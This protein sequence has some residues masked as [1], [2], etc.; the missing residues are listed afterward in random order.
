MLLSLKIKNIALIDKMQIDFGNGFHVLTGETG[1][2]KSII[3]DAL[4]LIVGGRAD[5]SLIRSSCDFALVEATVSINNLPE[6]K[7]I[8]DREMISYE[9][10]IIN[11]YRKISTSGRN[12]CRICGEPVPLHI[13]K[14]L[15]DNVIDILGQHSSIVLLE[16]GRQLKV[17][18]NFGDSDHFDKLHNVNQK[19][20][21]WYEAS[22]KLKK[23]I[24]ISKEKELLYDKVY[25][26]L[27]ELD[28]AKIRDGE[29]DEL[30][31][32]RLSLQDSLKIRNAL[33]TSYYNLYG[34]ADSDS[35]LQK[36]KDCVDEFQNIKDLN[37][38][39]ER[40]YNSLNSSYYEIENN[41]FEIRDYRDNLNFDETEEVE[42][43]ERI[44]LIKRLKRKYGSSY[45]E[46]HKKHKD[47]QAKMDKYTSLDE[48]ISVAEKNYKESLNSYREASQELSLSRKAIAIKF[49]KKI[50]DQLHSLGMA[51]AIFKIEVLE[52]KK[53]KPQSNGNDTVIF[54][55]SSN[56]GEPLKP[57]ADA[58][59]GGE[60][61]R[62]MLAIKTIEADKNKIPCLIFDEV[63]TGISG[64]AAQI[65]AEK[66]A[67]ISK[68]R[69]V[70]AVSHLA[71]IACMADLHFFVSKS[72]K[73]TR[74]VTNIE[75]LNNINRRNEI[76][77]LLGLVK[78]NE[79]TALEHADNMLSAASDFK[80]AL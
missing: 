28:N 14:E 23:L 54:T 61:S 20:F 5:K 24:N 2:G 62:I 56:K 63:D 19:Y 38:N 64:R 79:N 37:K 49:G 80:N 29:E 55:F 7:A 53:L 42:I 26:E 10:N 40:I 11:V 76:A 52:D 35:V 17:L 47:L 70:F 73:D 6:V 34:F 22:V 9:G 15:M 59:S 43:S 13:L 32:R 44:E 58:A 69:Q 4:N 60:L 45:E 48:N 3:V 39:Y 72:D 30:Y 51:D 21:E 75:L 77:R 25:K 18:D 71:Q 74:T 41:L 67:Y 46:I 1:A 8:L 16:E 27:E 12:L 50:C 78:N 36:L 65:V 33:K 31:N 66:I 57:I 68:F